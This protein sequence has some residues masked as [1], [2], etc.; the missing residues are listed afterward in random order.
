LPALYLALSP[1]TAL[2]EVSHGF[3]HRLEPLVLCSYDVDCEDVVD[4]SDEP[5]R[6]AAGVGLDELECAWAL[7]L[8]AGRRPA[9]HDVARRLLEAGAAGA[10]VPSFATGAGPADPNL[11]LW[12]WGPELPHRVN[13]YDPSGRL[14]KNQLSWR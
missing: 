7:E 9:S 6:R 3:A 2:R 12:R 1:V 8:A 14:P 13:V 4:L 11:V 10:I 5:S